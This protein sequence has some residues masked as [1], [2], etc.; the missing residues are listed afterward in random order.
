[1]FMLTSVTWFSC[2]ALFALTGAWRIQRMRRLGCVTVVPHPS[3]RAVLAIGLA[4]SVISAKSLTAQVTTPQGGDRSPPA[5]TVP[6]IPDQPDLVTTVPFQSV[7]G[8]IFFQAAV[9]ERKGVYLLDTGSPTPFFLPRPEDSTTNG[10]QPIEAHTL[11]IG[12]LSADIGPTVGLG[13]ANAFIQ[14]N[15]NFHRTGWESA[16]GAIGLN[17]LLPFEV[18]ID[19]PQQRLTFVRLDS[20]GHR[21]V[22]LPAY[23]PVRTV[24]LTLS[25]EFGEHYMLRGDAGGE[26]GD[27][28]LDTGW[29]GTAQL[30]DEATQRWGKHLTPTRDTSGDSVN[31]Y[32]LDHLQIAGRS[33]DD[34]PFVAAS[35]PMNV[36]SA[37]FLHTLGVIGLNFKAQ[38]LAIYQ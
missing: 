17:A 9:D 8:M 5:Q 29:W 10:L 18:I 35:Y 24:P 26:Q 33:L 2:I 6:G 25:M 4:W 28:L 20:A 22:A 36:I 14:D 16:I 7:D 27:F 37:S 15:E 13:G 1:M 11:H 21:R 23:T 12:T 38:Q 34:S 31:V 30:T 19:Y 32:H 3:Q